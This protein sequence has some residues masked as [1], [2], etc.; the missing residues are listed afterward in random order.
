MTTAIYK[1]FADDAH[2]G[3]EVLDIRETM[4]LCHALK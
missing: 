3:N 2:E 4:E 1:L